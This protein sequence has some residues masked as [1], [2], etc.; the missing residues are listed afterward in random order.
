MFIL[1]KLLWL[2]ANPAALLALGLAI[3]LAL[4]LFRRRRRLGFAILVTGV[5]AFLVNAVV[6][7]GL[8]L[9]RALEDR[10]PAPATLPERVDGIIVLSGFLRMATSADRDQVQVNE[11]ADRLTALLSLAR[12]YPDARLVFTGGS[13]SIFPDAPTEASLARVLLAEIGA[14]LDRITFEDRSRNTAENARYSHELIR[15]GPGT[16]WLLVTSAFH[17][18]RA[19]AC[20]R[21]VGW[22]VVPYP[23]DYLTGGPGTIDLT[24][25]PVNGLAALNLAVHEVVGLSA[26]RVLGHTDELWP[27]PEG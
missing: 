27:A 3:G 14:P 25:D 19:V 26:Y 8:Y 9:M 4:C 17:M 10:F 22:A 11:S 18:P 7:T 24:F 6:P 13:A 15:P 2:V 20:F 1:S 12:R 5:A 16:T 21:K 23:T